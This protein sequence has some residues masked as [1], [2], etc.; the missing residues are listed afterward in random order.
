MAL[1][2]LT[3]GWRERGRD[4]GEEGREEEREN[5]E[6]YKKYCEYNGRR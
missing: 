5:K 4:E 6:G 1:K 3:V 2:S